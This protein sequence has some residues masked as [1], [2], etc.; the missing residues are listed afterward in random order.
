MHQYRFFFVVDRR[1]PANPYITIKDD[2]PFRKTIRLEMQSSAG[3][4]IFYTTDGSTPDRF[5]RRYTGPI[6]IEAEE[7]SKIG[8]IPVQAVAR[9]DNGNSSE[10]VRSLLPF[11]REV[12]QAPSYQILKQDSNGADI[13]IDH[14]YADSEIVYA[15]GY[16]ETPL[17]QINSDSPTVPRLLRVDFP[18]G[19]EG[20][21]FLRFAARDQARNLS[22]STATVKIDVDSVPPAPPT[23]KRDESTISFEGE[24]TIFYRID[25]LHS[26]PRQYN[27]PINL[28]VEEGRK[29]EYTVVYYS[30]DENE[31]RSRQKT[32]QIVID[33]RIPPP[34][35]FIPD[36]ATN[37]TNDP[38]SVQCIPPFPDAVIYYQ[39]YRFTEDGSISEDSDTQAS[40]QGRAP[41]FDDTQYS[42]PIQLVGSD[43]REI[44]YLLKARSYVPASDSWSDTVTTEFTIDRRPP[45]LPDLQNIVGT[46]LYSKPVTLSADEAAENQNSWIYV[47]EAT[48]SEEIDMDKIISE[49]APL[50]K[51]VTIS[52]APG[53]ERNYLVAIASIDSAGN[54]A[55]GETTEIIIDRQRP[56]PPA[57]QGIPATPDT[58]GPVEITAPSDYRHKI[59]YELSTDG[60]T[61]PKPDRD[62]DVLESE[63]LVLASPNTESETNIYRLAY[64]GID[65]AG[66]MSAVKTTHMRVS[67]KVPDPPEIHIE[68]LGAQL[69]LLKIETDNDNQAYLKLNEGEFQAF[70]REVMFYQSRKG[71]ALEVSAYTENSYGIRSET[72]TRRISYAAFT[73]SLVEGVEK[74]GLY[75]EDVIIRPTATDTDIRY[76]LFT[77][78]AET[79]VLGADSPSLSDSLSIQVARG[80]TEHF[81][82]KAGVYDAETNTVLAKQTYSFTID[83]AAPLPPDIVGIQSD[84]HYT[85]DQTVR[86]LPRDDATIY[87]RTRE[88]SG[89]ETAYRQYVQPE[90]VR[91]RPGTR[92]DIIV[93]A[94][95][96][97]QAGNQSRV[98]RQEFVID[99]ASIYVAPDGKDAFSG[100]KENPFRSIDR[101]LYEAR[102][103][104]RNTIYL[105]SG[106][107]KISN[108]VTVRNQL[109][110]VGGLN[111]NTWKTD[112]SGQTFLSIGS[113]F[114]ASKP[115]FSIL[116]GSLKLENLTLSNIDL[117][118]ALCVQEGQYSNLIIR[119]STVLHANGNAP[120][121]IWSKSG[122]FVFN[123]SL[124]DVGP[125]HNGSVLR[126]EDASAV[127]RSSV[128]SSDSASGTLTLLDLNGADIEI[129]E[130]E[131]AAGNSE[132]IRV[133]DAADSEIEIS[134]SAID[135]G[136][137]EVRS[138]G[139]R[140]IRGKLVM[141]NATVGNGSRP[142]HIASAIEIENI[143]A[144]LSGLDMEGSAAV[145]LVQFRSKDS[146]LNIVNSRMH[147]K[148]TR[149]FSYLLRTYGGSCSVKDSDLTADSSYDV[150][151]IELHNDSVAMLQNS[152]LELMRGENNTIGIAAEG[153]V[154]CTVQESR[155][156]ARR[157]SGAASTGAADTVA[158]TQDT[159]SADIKL[160]NN[161]FS[162]WDLLLKTPNRS[163]RTTEELQAEVPPFD[164]K[165]PHRGNRVE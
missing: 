77:Q 22:S 12:P 127:L 71:T 6:T 96:E 55:I 112:S 8:V 118:N 3:A 91:V 121:I 161:L 40:A 130:S 137:A 138:T 57:L 143:N 35:D 43:N 146:S 31:N 5:S 14:P 159:A 2:V 132:Y 85:E 76:E 72:A 27:Q 105:A 109:N 81:V 16:G 1:V 63:P 142:A 39:L 84:Y 148:R 45:Q 93:E 9:Y 113:D 122:N 42:E 78:N 10:V 68:Q 15:I 129:I 141:H 26:T 73:R 104:N 56:D 124:I 144:E 13:K 116:Q 4:D 97:D 164:K 163:A 19:F 50:R 32:E 155:L 74:G 80:Q 53:E 106:D 145:G 110:I 49:G 157:S 147:N 135:Y 82:F 24:G 123:N 88:A 154:V 54:S 67:R 51:G 46:G 99:K 48:E 152:S 111:K 47:E 120:T 115:L 89:P 58:G 128:I 126:I 114:A 107:Y 86:I 162:G 38:L 102:T 62:S 11:D 125:V 98:V 7:S 37:I 44:R 70:D 64:C 61:P 158:V 21:A 156:L 30:Q 87:F 92:K 83:K 75:N 59:V 95:S 103:T 34:P 17:L 101:A 69:F 149:E 139:I 100:G 165:T 20:G 151:G 33:N 79:N 90:K 18:S 29:K 133:I 160:V 136:A 153:P 119:N 131:L 140:H 117:E 60:S 150:Y 28:Q 94:W 23:L 52:G 41:G 65:Q 25:P 134:N 36:S 66:N 108:P